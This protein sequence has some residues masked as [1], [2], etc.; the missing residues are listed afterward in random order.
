MVQ[1][2]EEWNSLLRLMK[3]K[4]ELYARLQRKRQTLD[5]LSAD[6][7]EKPGTKSQIEDSENHETKSPP[8]DEAEEK[9]KPKE[10]SV[11]FLPEGSYASIRESP[12]ML[13]KH[14][15]NSDYLQSQ[16]KQVRCCLVLII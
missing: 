6:S 8:T 15:L 7:N 2:E 16:Q 1:K 9:S 3:H 4:E 14:F 5:I 12:L 13:L 11:V 10:D